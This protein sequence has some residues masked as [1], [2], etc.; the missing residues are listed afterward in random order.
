MR[1]IYYF[2]YEF[3][4]LIWLN[5]WFK[6]PLNIVIYSIMVLTLLLI[7]LII[8]QIKKITNIILQTDPAKLELGNK[9]LQL[10]NV[11]YEEKMD[12]IT[13]LRN[14]VNFYEKKEKQ[15]PKRN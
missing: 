4:S 12:L 10:N 5:Y 11:V 1:K 15:E 7:L 8:W 9:L 14:E 6:L 3:N 2:L 13:S